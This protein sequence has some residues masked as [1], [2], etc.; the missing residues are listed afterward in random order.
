MKKIILSLLCLFATNLEARDWSDWTD[1]EKAEYIAYTFINYT[2][3]RQ[4]EL[5]VSQK[6]FP[7]EEHNRLFGKYPSD[8]TLA[9]G[10]IVSQT[11]YYL[12]IK[13]SDQ[14]PILERAR[15]TFLGTKL[16]I[17]WANDYNGIR[18]NKVW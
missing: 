14:Y 1:A 5:C 6:L 16:S 15:W 18:V 2:D 4:T 3:F 12:M 10:F 11:G 8:A 9:A 17:V 13:Y 7:C